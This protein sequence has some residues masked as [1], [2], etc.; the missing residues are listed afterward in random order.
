VVD[1]T[2][3]VTAKAMDTIG[4]NTTDT[5]NVTVQN[6]AP[7][8]V[9]IASIE[10]SKKVAGINTEAIATV[11]IVDAN[12][13]PIE[14][15]M[16]SGHWSGLASDSDSGVTDDNGKVLLQSDKVKNA[17]GTFTFRV[18]DVILSGWVYDPTANI[19]TSDSIT[20]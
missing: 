9:H 18:D 4:Q 20:V 7:T 17:Q 15:A 11:T 3:T 10:M 12:N 16:V 19:E 5:S 14:G 6:Q 8:N 1:G 13:N 2:H